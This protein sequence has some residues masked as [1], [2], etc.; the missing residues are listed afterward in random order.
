M[1]LERLPSVSTFC[2]SGLRTWLLI[3][4]ARSHDGLTRGISHLQ[5]C[6][7]GEVDCVSEE[8]QLV[9]YHG[10]KHFQEPPAAIVS[11]IGARGLPLNESD[12]DAIWAYPG[13]AIGKKI[14]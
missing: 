14:F 8:P 11:C 1:D 13:K 6:T 9:R 12:D 7:T 2:A 4:F 10:Y 5:V 3:I